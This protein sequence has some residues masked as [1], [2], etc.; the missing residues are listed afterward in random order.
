MPTGDDDGPVE[1]PDHR[2]EDAATARARDP[3]ID[4]YDRMPR[5]VPRAIALFFLGIVALAT[6]VWLIGKL[7]ELLVMLLVA[8]FLS[9]ALEPAVNWLQARGWR[10]GTGTAVVFAVLFV[11]GGLFV[12]AIGSLFVDQVQNLV[13]QAP[14]YVSD[15]AAHASPRPAQN[16]GAR[17][18]S[19]GGRP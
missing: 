7:R 8:L 19:A 13:D 14:E 17:V 10:R 2:E 18:D 15:I 4:D 6:S 9:F 1:A 3:R 5:W 16:R 11:A 12:Y